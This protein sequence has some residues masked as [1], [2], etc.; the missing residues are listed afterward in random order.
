[1]HYQFML[2]LIAY[3]KFFYFPFPDSKTFQAPS[4]ARTMC[5]C[6]IK[7]SMLDLTYLSQNPQQGGL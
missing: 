6:E 7:L 5:A 1:M 2:R 4:K 3:S